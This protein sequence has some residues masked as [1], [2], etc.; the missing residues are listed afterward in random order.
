MI[1]QHIGFTGNFSKAR[2]IGDYGQL[3]KYP[4]ESRGKRGRARF[5][6]NPG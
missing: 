5:M 2:R 6:Q 3:R 1:A 4:A